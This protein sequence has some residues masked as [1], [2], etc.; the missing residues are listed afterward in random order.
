MKD[1]RR[2]KYQERPRAMSHARVWWVAVLEGPMVIDVMEAPSLA[3]AEYV[4]GLKFPMQQTVCRLWSSLTVAQRA[5][6]RAELGQTRLIP[7][8]EG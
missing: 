2:H 4:A 6:A 3:Q 1:S 5:K 7:G 8:K